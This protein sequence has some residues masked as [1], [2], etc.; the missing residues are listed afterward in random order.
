[1][2]NIALLIMRFVD[3]ISSLLSSTVFNQY[4]DEV[5]QYN[6]MYV[7]INAQGNCIS[8]KTMSRSALI[9]IDEY[10]CTH[11]ICTLD[12]AIKIYSQ[13]F[14]LKIYDRLSLENR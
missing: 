6:M 14:W 9:K 3:V 2:R 7:F 1:M 10:L 13:C 5:K 12:Y 8:L 4:C 11:S